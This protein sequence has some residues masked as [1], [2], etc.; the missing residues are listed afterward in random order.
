M[1][2]TDIYRMVDGKIVEQWVEVDR[3]GFL[4]QLG[5]LPTPEHGGSETTSSPRQQRQ[6]Q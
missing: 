5:F 1:I 4:Q 2:G 3:L 6:E